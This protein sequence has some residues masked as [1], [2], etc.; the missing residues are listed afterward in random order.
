MPKAAKSVAPPAK[1]A[2]RPSRATSAKKAEPATKRSK[3]APAKPAEPEVPVVD[4]FLQEQRALLLAERETY[5]DQA[6][7]LKADADQLAAEMEPG[8]IQFDEESGEGG[9]LNV[10]RER[11]LALSAQAR[12]AVDEID[13]A[14][15]KV[16][17]GTYGL[18]EQCGE[19]IKRARLKA[20]PYASLCVACKSGG[21]SR[22]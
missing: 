8:D 15:A 21:L 4:K 13:R 22:R 18:C 2:A 19:P 12:A 14:L 5:V 6:E 7:S 16:D 11:D 17:G 20:L 10:E 3:S 1:Q 9:T